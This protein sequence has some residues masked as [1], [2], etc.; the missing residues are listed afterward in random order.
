MTKN[1][2]EEVEK[3]ESQPLYL[4]M[5]RGTH[6]ITFLDNGKE[7]VK[8]FNEG[9][10]QEET[11]KRVT[12]KVIHKGEQKFWEIS[13]SN[14]ENSA[15]GQIAYLGQKSGD[16]TNVSTKV[17]VQGAEKEKRYILL[18]IQDYIKEQLEK[19]KVIQETV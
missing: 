17:M 3:L 10:P 6:E 1:W 8:T 11:V 2:N 12:F 14:G 5:E 13:K 9:T 16:L 4:K 18:D 15:Y 7:S 19:K